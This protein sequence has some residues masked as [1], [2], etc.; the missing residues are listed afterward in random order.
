MEG[1]LT[2]HS[3]Y[4]ISTSGSKPTYPVSYEILAAGHIT[5]HYWDCT[6]SPQGGVVTLTANEAVLTP[7]SSAMQ[8]ST[9]GP[10]GTSSSTT[11]STSPSNP[12]S[13]SRSTT[14]RSS[15]SAPKETGSSSTDSEHQG[16]STG[17]ETMLGRDSNRLVI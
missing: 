5:Y 6:D 15:T 14:S 2:C 4:V 13:T 16:Y 10:K 9:S 11:P 3:D 1:L 17:G 12:T 7:P 8:R